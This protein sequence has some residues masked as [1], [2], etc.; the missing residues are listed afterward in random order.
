MRLP[1][2][3]ALF[4]LAF[5]AQN[6]LAAEPAW[7]TAPLPPEIAT[8]NRTAE[9]AATAATAARLYAQS[10]RLFPSNGPAL[11]GLGRAL[12]DQG[13]ASDALLILRRM[14][15]QFPNDPV[16]LE[17][18]AAAITRLPSLRRAHLAEGLG[19]A[20]QAIQLQPDDPEAWHVLSVLRHLNGDYVLALEAAQEAVALYEQ[21][22]ILSE[23]IELYQQQE[24][25][26]NDALLVF[27]PLD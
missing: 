10:L 18:L 19:F 15:S 25:A 26:C 13:R 3:T 17:A 16:V 5:L 8:L 23:T 9:S 20:E 24:I 12:L 4:L 6:S 2:A 11:Y 27:S 22:P 21:H 1:P 14:D 7:R